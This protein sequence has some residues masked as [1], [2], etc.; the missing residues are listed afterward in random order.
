MRQKILIIIG[1]LILI[2]GQNPIRSEDTIDLTIPKIIEIALNNNFKLKGERIS[3]LIHYEAIGIAE[4]VVDP[5]LTSTGTYS[6]QT[7]EDSPLDRESSEM[8]LEGGIGKKFYTG[9]N[10]SI[11]LSISNDSVKNS[12]SNDNG[13]SILTT[14]VITQPLLKNKGVQVNRRDVIVAENSYEIS[15]LVFKQAVIDTVTETMKRYWQLYS[16]IENLK[17]HKKS[18]Q[19]AKQFLSEV[20]ERV[21]IGNAAPLESLHAKAEVASR[22]EAVIAADN[23]RMNSQ[24]ELLSYIYGGQ[25]PIGDT[26]CLQEPVFE[27]I[28]ISEQELFEKAL[29]YRTD[30]LIA[31]YQISSAQTNMIY[32]KNQML[33]QVDLIGTIG[34]NISDSDDQSQSINTH[35][36]YA[37]T[38]S[39]TVKYP[40][41]L[42]K[43]SANYR[44]A[45]LTLKQNQVRLED[46]QAN[47]RLQIRTIMRTI[48][49]CRKRYQAACVS[50]Q[51]AEEKLIVENEKYQ[52]GLSTGYNVLLYQRDF[53]DAMVSVVNATIE[54]QL[55]VIELNRATGST[56]EKNNIQICDM[57]KNE[58]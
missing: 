48:E 49:S 23:R 42:K 39:L 18:L 33:P 17:V 56:L 15:K 21:S 53:I 36:Y 50:K 41:G 8:S 46:I 27:D 37:G 25:I 14:L 55:S 2:S 58:M 35:D 9:T 57:T 3:P 38:L 51:L 13:K 19:L 1:L 12:T 22:E 26:R 28:Q 45:L 31:Q 47:I 43:D 29:M 5:V 30:Y 44:S 40:W 4:A 16:S 11:N 6:R 34:Y 32:M 20:E 10:V 54:Y 24:D 52:N 7:V